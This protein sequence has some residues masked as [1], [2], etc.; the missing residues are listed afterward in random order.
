MGETTIGWTRFTFNPWWGC[1]EVSPACRLCY[2]R[3]WAK[4]MGFNVWG[5]DAE[6]RF[7]DDAH[8][9]QPLNWNKKVGAERA[10]RAT[11]VR[12]INAQ[13]SREH[14]GQPLPPNLKYPPPVDGRVFSASM[15]DVFE[16]RADLV[17]PRT[18]LFMT[19]MQTPELDWLLLTK[20]PGDWHRLT[21]QSL[22]LVKSWV[23]TPGI[24]PSW[25]TTHP[26]ELMGWILHW[27]TKG[28][29]P[30]QNVWF[31][32]TVENQEMA[33][34][35]LPELAGVRAAIKFLS[36]EPLLGKVDLTR[37]CNHWLGGIDWIIVGGE[38]GPDPKEGADGPRGRAEMDLDALAF[39]ERQTRPLST[40][41]GPALYVKQDSGRSPGKQGRI[42]DNIWKRKE[43]PSCRPESK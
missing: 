33:D 37:A 1:V 34:K 6:R 7:F 18:R 14:I 28:S 23:D 11:K 41:K 35:R 17:A 3:T 4:R 13:M 38:T 39:V 29:A 15:A 2:A 31:G 8:W 27:L 19:I 36:M 32:T 24:M 12:E 21:V 9:R 26:A 25:M 30:P 10:E 16:N 43:F 40:V 5:R 42:P 22:E 20:R